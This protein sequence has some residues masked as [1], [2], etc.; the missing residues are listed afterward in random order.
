[1]QQQALHKKG[2]KSPAFLDPQ[3]VM[4]THITLDRKGIV[5]YFVKPMSHYKDKE[6]LVVAFNTGNHWLL[7]SISTKYE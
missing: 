1:M 2:K 4:R 7:L 5:A 6:M 3:M